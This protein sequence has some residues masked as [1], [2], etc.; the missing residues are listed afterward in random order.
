MVI[1]ASSIFIKTLV[2]NNKTIQLLGC[3]ALFVCLFFET[4]ASV[5]FSGSGCNSQW[6]LKVFARDFWH[7]SQVHIL[8]ESN[9]MKKVWLWSE[10]CFS[11]QRGLIKVSGETGS[12]F[13]IQCLLATL[14]IPFENLLVM[15][16]CR[17]KWSCRHKLTIFCQSW[18]L[19]PNPFIKMESTAAYLLLFTGLCSA[20][21][22]KCI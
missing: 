8:P 17:L 14:C 19:F 21:L 6:V 22:S 20:S 18:N 1:L 7:C 16:F 10:G 12:H 4:S 3:L 9:E 15:Y 2:K 13:L 5:W 11:L